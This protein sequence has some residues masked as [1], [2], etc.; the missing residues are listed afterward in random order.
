[1]NLSNHPKSVCLRQRI[2]RLSTPPP[3]P[4]AQ[5]IRDQEEQEYQAALFIQKIIQGRA[6]QSVVRNLQIILECKIRLGRA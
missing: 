6:I 2:N 3:T 1:M 4:T 5:A